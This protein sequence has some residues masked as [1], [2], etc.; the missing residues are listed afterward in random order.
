VNNGSIRLGAAACGNVVH[1]FENEDVQLALGK[2]ASDRAADYAGTD[3]DY[4]SHEY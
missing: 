3:D 1:S 4:V 2:L